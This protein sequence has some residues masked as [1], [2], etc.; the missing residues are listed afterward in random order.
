LSC[1]I[2]KP[3]LGVMATR[4]RSLFEPLNIAAYLV[5]LAIGLEIWRTPASGTGLLPAGLVWPCIVVAHAAF[6]LLFLAGRLHSWSTR[7][8]QALA[9][10]QL[11]V[12]LAIVSAARYSSTP[13]LLIVVMAQNAALYTP[14]RLTFIFV[15]TNVAQ[16]VVFWRLWQVN[17]PL[18]LTLIHGSFQLFA[19]MT[20]WYAVTAQRSRDALA[21]A[22]A[23][24]V[25]TRS[26]LAESVRDAER[27]R[28]A[29]ELHDVLGHKLTALKLNL[30]LLSR[31]TLT[32]TEPALAISAQLA[33]ELLDDIRRVVQAQRQHQGID[34]RRAIEALAAPL[35]RPQL[36]LQLSD[37]VRIADI[38]QAD[39]LLRS[40]QEA[41]TN[42]ARHSQA[43]NLWIVV[44][45]ESGQLVLDMRDDGRGSGDIRFGA[46]LTGMRERVVAAHGS[47]LVGRTVTGGVQILATIPASA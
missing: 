42:T 16:F 40:A 31:D 38:T 41:L 28:L 4:L 27:L 1:R 6:L 46:G 14:P 8:H 45:Q 3:K 36:H 12:A 22:N 39:V 35:P 32:G 23:E 11:L 26:L 5:W 15:A 13:V 2:G 24:L 44:R 33:D 30:R 20:S 29:R 37:A 17:A 47:L 34:L 43:E 9:A 19:I 18:M 21:A 25:A 7:Q 10:M